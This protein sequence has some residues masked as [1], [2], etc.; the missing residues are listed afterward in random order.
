MN[1][2]AP[3]E[4]KAPPRLSHRE[5]VSILSGTVL[6]MFLAALDQTIVAPALTTIGIEL[7]DVEHLSWVVTA[8]LLTA[9]AVTPLYGKASDI[10]GRRIAMLVGVGL[11]IAGSILCALASS[12]VTLIIGRAVQGLGGGGLIALAQTII[13]D[14][15]APKERA[16]YQVFIAGVFMS[17]SLL[18]PVLGGYF[19]EKLH[20]TM[21]FWINLP[22]GALAFGLCFRLLKKLPRH[23]RPHRLDVLGALLMVV[24]TVTT[25]LALSW[26]GIRYPWLSPEVLGLFGIS[27]VLWVA[28]LA[29]MR[30]AP[31]PLIPTEIFANRVVTAATICAFF[32]Y[33][34][35]AGLTIYVPIYLQATFALDPAQTGLALVP[36]MVGT[37]AGATLSGRIMMLVTHYKRL[38]LVGLVVAFA[39]ALALAF[40][41]GGKPPFVIAELI[42]ALL[43]LGL[44]TMLP[45]TTISIQNAVAPHQMGTATGSMNFFRQLGGAMI[46]A[47]FGAILLSG[48]Q[49]RLD[50]GLTHESLASIAAAGPALADVFRVIFIAAALGIALAGA[51]L[52]AMEERPLRGGERPPPVAD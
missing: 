52:W 6:A 40:W 13:A 16:R 12:M 49:G 15:V 2:A 33:G 28:F 29:R 22:L 44:G 46:V 39:C 3:H 34:V 17:S 4:H 41:P 45:V 11:F 7:Q 36:L 24:A 35:F 31:E 37:V 30:L 42:F 25:M 38:P 8:Y 21:I 10:Y 18:G 23:E 47:V 9:T 43:S 50:A 14:L 48:F 32:G 26:G 5:I 27:A 1:D 20:W 51:A 19:S